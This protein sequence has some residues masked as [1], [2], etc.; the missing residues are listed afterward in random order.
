[1]IGTPTWDDV[2][3]VNGGIVYGRVNTMVAEIS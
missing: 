3:S 1:M 2:S